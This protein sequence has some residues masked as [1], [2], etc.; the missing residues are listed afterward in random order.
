MPLAVQFIGGEYMEDYLLARAAWVEKVF[1]MS[2]AIKPR[3]LPPV[4]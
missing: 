2:K 1:E 3:R 4:P